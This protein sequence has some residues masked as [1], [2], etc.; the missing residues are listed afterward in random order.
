MADKEKRVAVVTGANRGIGYAVAKA[1]SQQGLKVVLTA[2]D[3]EKGSKAAEELN[4]EGLDVVFKKL[5][6][7]DPADIEAFAKWI[8]KELGRADVLVNNAGVFLD[9]GGLFGASSGTSPELEAIRGSMET[10]V[11]G[12]LLLSAALMPLM[13]KLGYG[14]VVNVSSGMGQLSDMGG[15]SPGYRISKAAINAVTRVL[16]SEA[17]DNVKVNSA[18]PGWVRTRMGGSAAA[19]SPEEG[20]DTIVWLATLPDDGPTG[21]FFKDRQP[22]PW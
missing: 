5:D 22:I 9:G 7:A 10:N 19:R 6:V 1:L 18:S 12:P 17:G 16:A 20:A 3:E 13:K 11:Y 15:G 2:R 8:E 4:R 21:G 14:R